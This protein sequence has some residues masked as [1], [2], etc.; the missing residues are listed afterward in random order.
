MLQ[1][2]KIFRLHDS[3]FR[4]KEKKKSKSEIFATFPLYVQNSLTYFRY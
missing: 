1:R 3:F 2:C 4:K